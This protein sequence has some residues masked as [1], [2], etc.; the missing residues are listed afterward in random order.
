MSAQQT[1]HL[2]FS[3]SSDPVTGGTLDYAVL[4]C[5]YACKKPYFADIYCQTAS[6]LCHAGLLRTCAGAA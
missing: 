2:A 4:C 1:R 3:S 6:R 5:R